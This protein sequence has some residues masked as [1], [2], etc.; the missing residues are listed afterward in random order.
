MRPRVAIAPAKANTVAIVLNST[1]FGSKREYCPY[2]HMY[3]L[4]KNQKNELKIKVS[5]IRVSTLGNQEKAISLP[6]K[7]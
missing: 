2:L 1:A 5:Q 6:F 4:T 7:A 3:F